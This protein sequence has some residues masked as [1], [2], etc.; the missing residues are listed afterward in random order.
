MTTADGKHLEVFVFD[1]G[2]QDVPQSKFLFPREVPTNQDWEVWIFLAPTHPGELPAAHTLWS[3]DLHH[4]QK[5]E[6]VL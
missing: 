6:L 5:M 1:P 4:T 3:L 2:E